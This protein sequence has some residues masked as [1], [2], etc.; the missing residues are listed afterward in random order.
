MSQPP[1]GSDLTRYAVRLRDE[2][3][4]FWAKP[5]HIPNGE[6]AITDAGAGALVTIDTLLAE[7]HRLRRAVA[8]RQAVRGQELMQRTDEL[9]ARKAAEGR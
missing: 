7:L 4:T 9:I 8:D 5:E 6:L 1:P 2:L 3:A